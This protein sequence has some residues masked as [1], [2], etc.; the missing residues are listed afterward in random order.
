M[1]CIHLLVYIRTVV[2]TFMLL[3]ARLCSNEGLQSITRVSI[4]QLSM[5][6]CLDSLM[7]NPETQK[8]VCAPLA[9]IQS[10]LLCNTQVCIIQQ[11]CATK[12]KHTRPFFEDSCH[13][14]DTPNLHTCN[15]VNACIVCR[16]LPATGSQAASTGGP[17]L[18]FSSDCSCMFSLAWCGTSQAY[19]GGQVPLTPVASCHSP[20][21]PLHAVGNMLLHFTARHRPSMVEIA[22]HSACIVTSLGCQNGCTDMIS[23]SGKP[24]M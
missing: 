12:M 1:T 15:C 23:K 2:V 16:H 10:N 17:A 9:M 22:P 3:L 24:D 20:P 13:R 5:L 8:T 14:N 6:P 21:F 4:K 11:S 19:P 18:S 7:Y